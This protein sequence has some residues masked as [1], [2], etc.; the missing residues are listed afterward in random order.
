MSYR[1]I[2]FIEGFWRGNWVLDLGID[3]SAEQL[4][5]FS[6]RFTNGFTKNYIKLRYSNEST[7][8]SPTN[9]NMIRSIVFSSPEEFLWMQKKIDFFYRWCCSKVNFSNSPPI[10]I[11]LHSKNWS[12]IKKS[13]EHCTGCSNPRVKCRTTAWTLLFLWIR[14]PFFFGMNS[15][16]E[17]GLT[18]N[19]HQY[20]NFN[21]LGDILKMFIS[22][23]H[24]WLYG[25]IINEPVVCQK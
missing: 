21:K 12:I 9:S 20:P 11:I 23:T 7:S 22:V 5:E 24:F 19:T 4:V 1:R 2:S 8:E 17:K 3:T 15:V 13:R 18:L 25:G 10:F 16:L 6:Y 14:I